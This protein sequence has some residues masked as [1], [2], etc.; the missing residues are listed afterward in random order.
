[1]ARFV[2]RT[3]QPGAPVV[4]VQPFTPGPQTPLEEAFAPKGQ[5]GPADRQVM[6]LAYPTLSTRLELVRS[7]GG[8]FA[9]VATPAGSGIARKAAGIAGSGKL[10]V[11]EPVLSFQGRGS[12]LDNFLASL[13]PGFHVVGYRIFPGLGFFSIRVYVLQRAPGAPLADLLR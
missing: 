12:P 5:P 2:E 7:G 1:V 3:G 8:Y 13:P 10:F 9:P 6:T 4:D 11:T